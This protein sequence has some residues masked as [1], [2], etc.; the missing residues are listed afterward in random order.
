MSGFEGAY[1]EDRDYLIRAPRPTPRQ[2]PL[3][4]QGRAPDRDLRGGRPGLARLVRRRS[5]G[6]RRERR[7]V[8]RL[9]R[10]DGAG[11]QPVP[12]DDQ[13]LG[14]AGLAQTGSTS[15]ETS[16]VDVVASVKMTPLTGG[17]SP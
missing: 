8:G 10:P 2:Q 9:P 17:T 12:Q 1:S 5:R 14:P 4:A 16:S 6:R 15:T 13:A 11:R 7:R 3:Q